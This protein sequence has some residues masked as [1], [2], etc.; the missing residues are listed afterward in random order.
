MTKK[1]KTKKGNVITL[2]KHSRL[3]PAKV[4]VKTIEGSI[5]SGSINLGFESR[6]SD[7]FMDS[8]KHFVVMFDARIFG[9]AR[10][11]VLIIN[12]SHI[13]W[14]EPEDDQ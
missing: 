3:E 8:N 5:I 6:P 11:K 9:E 4:T 2:G 14:I 13:V 10:K 1:E 7:V 12:K